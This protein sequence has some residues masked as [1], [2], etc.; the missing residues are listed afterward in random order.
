MTQIELG[1]YIAAGQDST[2]IKSLPE[3]AGLL[4]F[5]IEPNLPR[6]ANP[7]ILLTQ[8]LTQSKRLFYLSNEIQLFNLEQVAVVVGDQPLN[9][10]L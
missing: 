7:H 10:R 5:T 6:A 1:S 4:I 8:L 2:Y 9:C 3:L